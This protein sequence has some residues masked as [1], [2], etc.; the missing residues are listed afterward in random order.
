[1]NLSNLFNQQRVLDAEIESKHP[2]Q[3]GEDRLEKKLLALSVELGECANDWRG[4]KFWSENQKAK[5]TLLEEFIDCLHFTLSIGNHLNI[6]AGIL[7]EL[8]RPVKS[9]T[10]E[11][12]FL[13]ATHEI[14]RL[15]KMNTDKRKGDPTIP[16]LHLFNTM[17][18]LGEMLGFTWEDILQAY[19]EKNAVNHERQ[20][21]GY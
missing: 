2:T 15:H 7:Y 20:K 9:E 6:R 12:Q 5:P 13:N 3:P 18:G 21:V 10:V 19:D 17:L 4:F 11:A 1:M 14:A 8:A 16:Y